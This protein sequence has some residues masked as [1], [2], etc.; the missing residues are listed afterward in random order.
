MRYIVTFFLYVFLLVL[1]CGKKVSAQH[2]NINATTLEAGFKNP[3]QASKPRTWYH[4]NSGNASKEGFTKD[5]KAIK[6]AGIGGVLVFNVTM[7]LPEGDVK[8]NS[9]E[10][11]DILAHGA[12]E[13][14][15]LGLSFGVHNCDG[16]TSSGGPWVTP[17]NAMKVVVNSQ[18]I[19][20]GGKKVKLT[21]PKPPARHNYYK[22]IAVLAY[23][24]LETE[25]I[26]ENV[27][28]IITS[29]GETFEIALATDKQ[30]NAYTN[31]KAKEW[32]QY[33]YGKA[34]TIR[35]M[36]VFIGN[37]K[38]KIRLLKSN[39][40]V[41]FTLVNTP[42]AERIG[43]DECY[44]YENLK[45][46]TARYFRIVTDMNTHIYEMS[47]SANETLDNMLEYTSYRRHRRAL[48]NADSKSYIK[49]EDILVLSGKMDES[50]VLKT[51]LPKGNWTIMRFGYTASGATNEPAS[52]EG[53]GL[54]VDKFS[55]KALKVHYD[56]F[57]GK[58]IKE[59]KVDAPNALQYVEIDSYEVGPQNWTDNMEQ[60]FKKRFGYD[61]TPF[62]L[63]YAGKY[64]ENNST[65]DAV[66][67][68]MK[69]LA[70]DLM[71][72]NY[73]DYFTELCHQDGL[74]SYV[75]PYGFIGPFNSLDAGRS[76][77]IPMGE[78]WLGKTNYHKRAAV[79]SGHIYGKNVISAEA[80]T[81]TKLNWSFHPALAKQKGDY[82]WTNGI[83]EYMFHRF[84]HQSNTHVK[85]GMSMSFVGS[86]IDRTQTWW[87][88]A[89]HEW[90]DY[91]AR[92]SYMLRQGNPVL[93]VL[94]FV[95]DR[96]P[97][98]VIHAKQMRPKLPASYKYDCVNSD[99]IINHLKVEN[100]KLK[101]PN[102]I[103]YNALSLQKSEII[104]LE[105][106]RGLHKLS[107]QGA[108]IVGRKPKKLGGYLVTEAMQAE[109]KTLV[110]AIWSN[111]KT[112]NTGEW[113]QILKENNIQKDL[114]VEGQPDFN[115]YHRRTEKE[116]IY[117]V[118]NHN[119]KESETLKCSFL[120]D[121]KVPELWNAETSE[122][123]KLVEYSN[124]NGRTDISIKMNPQES[125]FV[126]FREAKTKRPKITY[127]SSNTLPKPLF[128]LDDKGN[129]QMQAY[130]N[131]NYNALLDGSENWNVNVNDIPNPIEIKGSWQI[132]FR[133]EDNYKV[134]LKTDELFDWTT[135]AEEKIKHYSGT[136]IYKTAFNIEDGMLKSNRQF[137]LNLGKV[138]VI[139]KV[140]VNGNDIGVSWIAPYTLNVTDALKEGEN[141]LEIQVT[142]QWTNRLIGDEKLPNQT[143]YDVRRTKRGFGD[144]DYRGKFKKMPDWYR[145]DQPLPDGPRTTFSAYSFQKSTDKLLPS[146]LIGP[147]TISTSKII[148]KNSTK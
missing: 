101:L 133:E 144:E 71:A 92:G 137:E 84:A 76:A 125:V 25:L 73:F 89:G 69:Q 147:V 18:L 136:A 91:L 22:D 34:H 109:F 93:D 148:K 128:S 106:L 77:D 94:V 85:P 32:V 20:E 9:Q 143:G 86:H 45:P 67:W 87:D 10:H 55:K 44:F 130:T 58:L 119:L 1:S 47:L 51:K 116:D 21:L 37:R 117:F 90:F 50:G 42:K 13:C 118:Y 23:P 113:E 129:L 95:G 139:A 97:S 52:D 141:S 43:K 31:L 36:S 29:S 38:G 65:I 78:F 120:V 146:G 49:K 7:G 63:M 59:A 79:S 115:F 105:T 16:W 134:T 53:T 61:F 15:Q 64:V 138:N 74:I 131:G 80:F 108:L 145:N 83:N 39:D 35:S 126:V 6:E 2:K 142:N 66:F 81:S 88:N 82:E 4:I 40:G 30:T 99:V 102:G 56:A 12:K 132:N 33:D 68:D 140:L 5:L 124:I 98:H 75:E 100:G 14:E 122:I 96:A 104:N 110:S 103:T 70:S 3:P 72:T 57:V 123:T 114:I 24:S 112:Y 41:D 28:P 135:H 121:G 60:L 19:V 46:V 26:D 127:A 27:N 48:K 8:Y 17:E 62:L 11:R 54:E 111:K 107:Q